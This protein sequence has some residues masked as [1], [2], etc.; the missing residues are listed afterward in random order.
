[1]GGVKKRWP[2]GGGVRVSRAGRPPYGVCGRSARAHLH[3][4]RSSLTCVAEG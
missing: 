1:V 4:C 2:D 3:I